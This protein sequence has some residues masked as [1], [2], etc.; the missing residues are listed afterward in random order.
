MKKLHKYNDPGHGWLRVP[1]K[2]LQRVGIAQTIS[3]CSY[4][5]GKHVYLEEDS[6]A[7]KYLNAIGRNNVDIVNHYTDNR[8]HIRRYS[9]FCVR[10]A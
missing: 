3:G 9:D 7:P 8:S 2:E 6:D 1:L 5:H 4:Q 10:L